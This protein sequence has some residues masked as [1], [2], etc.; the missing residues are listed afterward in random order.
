MGCRI[1]DRSRQAHRE[2]EAAGEVHHKFSQNGELEQVDPPKPPQQK[3]TAAPGAPMSPSDPV[4][5]LLLVEKGLVTGQELEEMTQ[6][7]RS[8]GL[9]I[10]QEPQS[11]GD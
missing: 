6:R 11:V 7:L 5:R 8:T 1:C 10:V 4:L 2:A 3:Q 9:A